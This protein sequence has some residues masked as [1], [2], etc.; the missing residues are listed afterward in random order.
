MAIGSFPAGAS[1][2]LE[3]DLIQA[4]IAGRHPRRILVDPNRPRY[5]NIVDDDAP[6]AWVAAPSEYGG[7]TLPRPRPGIRAI[8]SP[9][10]A[11]LA[12]VIRNNWHARRRQSPDHRR[13]CQ[14]AG[15]VGRTYTVTTFEDAPLLTTWMEAM[16]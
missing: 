5:L 7:Y 15:E 12:G 10:N 2:A 4:R 11:G 14:D 9:G 3:I 1:A 6:N 8:V 13:H 16:G